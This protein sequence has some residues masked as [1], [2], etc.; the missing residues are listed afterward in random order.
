MIE[1]LS[2]PL[3]AVDTGTDPQHIVPKRTE[4]RQA[5][6]GGGELTFAP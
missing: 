3:D 4:R 2:G 1:E 6:S 5:P